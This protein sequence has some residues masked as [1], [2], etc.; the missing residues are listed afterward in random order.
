[1]SW[2]TGA[3]EANIEMKRPERKNHASER[4][5]ILTNGGEVDRKCGG[6][7]EPITVNDRP[8]PG[9]SRGELEESGWRNKGATE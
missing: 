2:N 4:E 7:R 1:M 6:G 9:R 8:G 5:G 3:K